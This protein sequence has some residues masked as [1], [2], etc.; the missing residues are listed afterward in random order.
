MQS[1]TENSSFV[2]F[3]QNKLQVIMEKPKK[4][5]FIPQNLVWK[6]I[7]WNLI[8]ACVISG[9]SLEVDENFALLGYRV[10]LVTKLSWFFQVTLLAFAS[11]DRKWQNKNEEVWTVVN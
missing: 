2:G 6:A 3:Q 5:F 10:V 11:G 9:F 1:K 4:L 8:K 7:M